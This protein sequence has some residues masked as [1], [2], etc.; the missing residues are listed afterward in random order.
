MFRRRGW[1]LDYLGRNLGEGL[2]VVILPNRH[3]HG[4]S[5]Y[6]PLMTG[7]RSDPPHRSLVSRMQ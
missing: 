2:I 1:R 7:N 3:G 4:R 6:D 5:S